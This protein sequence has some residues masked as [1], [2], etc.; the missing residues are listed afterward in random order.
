MHCKDLSRLLANLLAYQ[1]AQ[2]HVY[3]Q[4]VLESLLNLSNSSNR[5]DSCIEYVCLGIQLL[6]SN[7]E[8]RHAIVKENR[9]VSFMDLPSHA[10]L[11]FKNCTAVAFCLISVDDESRSSLLN[12][13]ESLFKLLDEGTIQIQRAAMCA[14][15]NLAESV[16]THESLINMCVVKTISNL[17]TI[18]TDSKIVQEISRLLAF[19]S[20][21]DIAKENIFAHQLLPYLIKFSR[22]T[23]KETQRYSTLVICHLILHPIKNEF[24]H[25]HD[26][27]RVLMFLTK[28]HDLH[29][30]RCSILSLGILGFGVD[31]NCKELIANDEIFDG[32]LK[33]MHHEHIP[34]KQTSSLALNCFLLNNS[35]SM[36]RKWQAKD[37]EFTTLSSMLKVADAF[38][39]HNAMYL[40][41]S[42][43]ETAIVRHEL[44]EMGYVSSVLNILQSTSC[45]DTKN[46]C[47]YFFSVIYEY[48]EYHSHA[49]RNSNEMMAAVIDLLGSV[50]YQCKIY[51]VLISVL[52]ASHS[53]VQ[54]T[55]VK[56]GAVR[57]LSSIIEMEADLFPY[58]GFALLKLAD[59]F[60][61]HIAFS[62]E[63]GIR[64]LMKLGEMGRKVDG[65]IHNISSSLSLA[66]LASNAIK[67]FKQVTATSQKSA[68]VSLPGVN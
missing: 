22:R 19:I 41:G 3:R 65:G 52:L 66:K 44:I 45:V 2:F 55:L 30:E 33:G 40:V 64:A 24:Y 38:C 59:N 54:V 15:A 67:A 28:C 47:A 58:A 34:I 57:H 39:V 6:C 5:T 27:L 16:E 17:V 29:V 35:D 10:N 42:L 51:G 50:N 36:R 25:N 37:I 13:L 49:R 26:L 61:N 20:T 62:E 63:G 9:V 56:L 8:V 14:I 4:C 53:D 31:S 7:S 21:N 48:S 46:A 32:L 23:D 1:D 12:I 43:I 18:V 68:S 60:E 11:Q